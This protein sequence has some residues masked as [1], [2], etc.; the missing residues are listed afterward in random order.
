[1]GDARNGKKMEAVELHAA[2]LR[3]VESLAG[4]TDCLGVISAQLGFTFFQLKA[5]ADDPGIAHHAALTNLPEG[6]VQDRLDATRG[7]TGPLQALCR[8]RVAAFSWSELLREAPSND[9][10][11][12]VARSYNAF[13]VGDGFFVPLTPRDGAHGSAQFYVRDG[14]DLPSRSFP[15]AQYLGAL[16]YDSLKRIAFAGIFPSNTSPDLTARQLECVQLVARGRS[17][18]EIGQILGISEETVHKHVK[19]AMQRFDVTTRTQLV[20]RALYSARLTYDVVLY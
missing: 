14:E 10:Y 15:F 19:G 3:S 8:N 5:Y 13:G 11:R 20:V 4:L 1:V 16:A 12:A 18:R 2:Q 7:G 9:A 17:D 6:L